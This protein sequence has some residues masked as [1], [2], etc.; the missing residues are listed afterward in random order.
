MALAMGLS[1]ISWFVVA[2]SSS[3][4]KAFVYHNNHK[5]QEIS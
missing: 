3:V 1:L 2:Q 4:I 5:L